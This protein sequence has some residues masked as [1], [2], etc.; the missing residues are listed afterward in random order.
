MRRTFRMRS[1]Y[2][3]NTYVSLRRAHPTRASIIIITNKQKILNNFY[4]CN[5]NDK[6]IVRYEIIIIIIRG[7]E[8]FMVVDKLHFLLHECTQ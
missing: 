7:K 2:I 4:I 8:E 3:Y 6:I 5:S 1:V